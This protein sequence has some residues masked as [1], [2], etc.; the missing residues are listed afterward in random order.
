M[1]YFYL[2]LDERHTGSRQALWRTSL[3][4]GSG[5]LLMSFDDSSAVSLRSAKVIFS[6]FTWGSTCNS[7]AGVRGRILLK[8]N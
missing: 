8:C 6:Q 7:L 3:Q 1:F 4:I 5:G 2:H